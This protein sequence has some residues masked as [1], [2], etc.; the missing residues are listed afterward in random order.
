MSVSVQI[1][2]HDN[3]SFALDLSPYLQR[4]TWRIGMSA[5]YADVADVGMAQM[6][7][8]GVDEVTAWLGLAVQIISTHDDITRTH[9]RGFVQEVHPTAG[10]HSTPQADLIVVCPLAL[11]DAMQVQTAAQE[12]VTADSV[13]HDLI[14]AARPRLWYNTGVFR[15]G[16][17]G[18]AEVGQTTQLPPQAALIGHEF[19]EGVTVF[20]HVGD[21]WDDGA[22]VLDAVRHVVQAER[23]RFYCNRQGDYVFRNRRAE[24]MPTPPAAVFDNDMDDLKLAYGGER[25][26]RVGVRMTPR[27]WDENDDAVLW[28][29]GTAL[30]VP[31]DSRRIFSAHFQGDNHERLGSA[32]V[33]PPRRNIDYQANTDP[34]G[35]GLNMNNRLELNVIQ[36][37]GNRA[38]LQATNTSFLD[39]YLLAG[40][41]L[42]G[43]AL[44]TAPPITFYTAS[45]ASRQQYGGRDLHLSLD[46]LTHFDDAV[47]I[48]HYE[49]ARRQS[50]RLL[51]Q[52]I[53]LWGTAHTAAQLALTLFDRVCINDTDYHI[54][55]EQHTIP[56]DNGFHVTQWTLE[57]VNPAGFWL[58]DSGALD[59]DTRLA[60]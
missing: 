7:V 14:T 41:V 6:T 28:R 16:I 13:L 8:Q 55:A 27:T 38:Q 4:L 5:P 39:V 60:Y 42:H 36:V 2:I 20:A 1:D 24:F 48:A 59:T 23:G 18:A 44:H 46:G 35:A 34:N 54:I 51:A 33:H 10:H 26:S 29:L 11:L 43:R 40:A 15:V 53:T 32:T 45:N 17:I 25:V 3:H 50:P 58:L 12:N 56:D 9:F 21:G 57:A 49:L 37:D 47:N 31:A 52:S 30:R 19:D 22:N